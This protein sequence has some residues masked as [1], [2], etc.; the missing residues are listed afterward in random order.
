L[1]ED[2]VYQMH[3]YRSMLRLQAESISIDLHIADYYLI[4]GIQKDQTIGKI[5][6][7][8]LEYDPKF[9]DRYE[10]KRILKIK[11]NKRSRFSFLYRFSLFRFDIV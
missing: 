10:Y 11:I 1:K 8:R 5:R 4:V 7:Y 2:Y 3:M 9:E 6:I